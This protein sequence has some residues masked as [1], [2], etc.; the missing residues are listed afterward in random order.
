MA[1]NPNSHQ[2]FHSHRLLGQKGELLKVK[3]WIHL[4]LQEETVSMTSTSTKRLANAFTFKI[5]I[6]W[7]QFHGSWSKAHT[8]V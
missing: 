6:I 4:H 3:G 2:H 7:G 5:P 8:H 1:L